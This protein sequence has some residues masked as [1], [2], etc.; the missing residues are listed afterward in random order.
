MT[1]NDFAALKKGDVVHHPAQ[2]ERVF[3]IVG[4]P[5][6]YPHSFLAI[7][8]RHEI[9]ENNLWTKLLNASDE[10]CLELAKR[11]KLTVTRLVNP[12]NWDKESRLTYYCLLCGNRE[13]TLPHICPVFYPELMG[14]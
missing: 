6:L 3:T 8:G 14:K 13:A 9:N 10:K 2:S 4:R 5:N 1:G 12:G 11:F 7:L